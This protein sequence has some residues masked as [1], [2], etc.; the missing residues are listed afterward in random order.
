MLVSFFFF[1]MAFK[2]IPLV[3]LKTTITHVN[4]HYIFWAVL[5]VLFS[6]VLRSLR[7]KI[8]LSHGVKF[9]TCF[10]VLMTGFM[11][12]CVLPGRAGEVTR[13]VLISQRSS[14]SFAGALSSVLLERLFDLFTLLVFFALLLSWIPISRSL[15]YSF[16]E[17][18]LNA[19]LLISLAWWMIKLFFVLLGGV[20]LL[21]FK[22]T[23]K[24][25]EMFIAGALKYVC[26]LPEKIADMLELFLFNPLTL[27]IRHFV[28]GIEAVKSSRAFI[29]VMGL[30][31]GIW[32]VQLGSFWV[33]AKA[34]PGI[35]LGIVELAFVM[36]V[37]SFFI[38]IPSVPGYWG[39][40][41]AGGMFAMM[42][43][44]I[45]GAD[46]AGY[47]LVNHAVQIFPVMVVGFFSVL[48]IPLCQDRSRLN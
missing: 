39:V 9:S 48:I 16:G 21:A 6:C 31:F 36:V 2:N 40:W 30:S 15:S 11:L 32:L 13:P 42:V 4:Y 47:Q 37:I 22:R 19:A 17:Y 8:L 27:F 46:A 1:Q 10:H 24:I 18:E 33:V 7:W 43:F 14:H 25:P 28:T 38:A 3:E 29:S 35:S 45:S 44:N 23:R 20:L 34:V 41:E 12:N 26:V 5:I